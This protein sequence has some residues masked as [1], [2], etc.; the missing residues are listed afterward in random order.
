MRGGRGC[1]EEGVERR[2]GWQERSGGGEGARGGEAPEDDAG[3]GGNHEDGARR[4][5]CVRGESDGMEKIFSY[6]LVGSP[7]IGRHACTEVQQ[8]RKHTW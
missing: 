6:P 5:S 8:G 7:I 2:R 3:R 4:G 1:A